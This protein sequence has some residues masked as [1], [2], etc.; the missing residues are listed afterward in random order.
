MAVESTSDRA[1]FVSTDEFGDAATYTLA[2]G[3]VTALS[4]IFSTPWAEGHRNT[5]GLATA[6]PEFVCRTADL[7]AGAKPGDTLAVAGFTHRVL[8]LRP[9]QT[10]MTEIA[11]G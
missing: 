8:Q 7:P 10:G 4:G 2:G 11:L 9:D 1:T 3:G 5:P 6:K